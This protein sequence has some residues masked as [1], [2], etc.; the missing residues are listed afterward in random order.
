MGIC[1]YA[2]S[3]SIP[4]VCASSKKNRQAEAKALSP[5]P[6][7][8]TAVNS[9]RVH[10]SPK[11]TNKTTPVIGP[12]AFAQS[13]VMNLMTRY[14][15]FSLSCT[16]SAYMDSKDPAQTPEYAPHNAKLTHKNM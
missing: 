13:L 4:R 6:V 8:N 15:D 10:V 12:A 14:L 1:P 7:Q 2:A 9:G 11:H 5:M 3:D 16:E